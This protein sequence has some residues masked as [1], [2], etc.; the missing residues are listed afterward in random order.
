MNSYKFLLVGVSDY[1]CTGYPTLPS[2]NND[3]EELERLLRDHFVF[4]QIETFKDERTTKENLEAGINNFFVNCSERDT[5]I[6]YWSGHGDRIYNS[7]LRSNEGYLVC[8]DSDANDEVHDKISMQSLAEVIDNSNAKAVLV[9]IDCCYSG[10]IAKSRIDNPELQLA[11]SGKVIITAS[12]DEKAFSDES[13]GVFTKYLLEELYKVLQ[14]D[15]Y[16]KIDVTELYSNIVI[17]MEADK[18]N[19]IPSLKASVQGRFYLSINNLKMSIPGVPRGRDIILP[20][21][22][23]IIEGLVPILR[24]KHGLDYEHYVKMINP[25]LGIE[26]PL[27]KVTGLKKNPLDESRFFISIEIDDWVK[28]TGFIMTENFLISVSTREQAEEI[29]EAAIRN[30]VSIFGAIDKNEQHIF[31]NKLIM[32]YKDKQLELEGLKFQYPVREIKSTEKIIWCFYNYDSTNF[33]VIT[34]ATDSKLSLGLISTNGDEQI[35]KCNLSLDSMGDFLEAK[36]YPHIDTS[37]IRFRHESRNDNVYMH[38]MSHK[39]I[40]TT[41]SVKIKEN[42]IPIDQNWYVIL[43]K[44]TI[45]LCTYDNQIVNEHVFDVGLIG[46]TPIFHGHVSDSKFYV[47]YRNESYSVNITNSEL[48][49]E[50]LDLPGELI[51]VLNKELVL[52]KTY[53]ELKIYNIE[54]KDSKHTKVETK[55]ELMFFDPGIVINHI[56]ISPHYDSTNSFRYNHV[57]DYQDSYRSTLYAPKALANQVTVSQ[58]GNNLAILTMEGTILIW[59]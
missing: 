54:T 3:I 35:S 1:L 14:Y 7:D 39:E 6:L 53:N 33:I 19:Q 37:V 5:L 18:H 27:G 17:S 55:G 43:T 20:K 34:I 29:H 22:R 11:G 31:F 48:K 38:S 32:K 30:Q 25:Y 52:L 2:V 24:N 15:G 23:K 40:D 51:K 36:Y 42:V 9:I 12:G 26:L 47:T 8:K 13:N 56:E 59:E 46:S 58:T 45:S 41:V 21:N 57:F 44:R 28:N 4:E 49:V 50:A 10:L 16:Q